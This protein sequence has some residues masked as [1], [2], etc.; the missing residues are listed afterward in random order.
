MKPT[1]ATMKAA[2]GPAVE[3]AHR[4]SM[5]TASAMAASSAAMTTAATA[6]AGDKHNVA[7]LLIWSLA[8][9]GICDR[10]AG[11]FARA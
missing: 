2:H 9:S 6:V 1:G 8:I 10:N 3:A 7:L 4:A 5:K 11:D